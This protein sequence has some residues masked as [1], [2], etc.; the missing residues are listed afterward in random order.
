MASL[1]LQS[2]GCST[3]FGLPSHG[4]LDARSE[5]KGESFRVALLHLRQQYE[6]SKCLW[7]S[8]F[9]A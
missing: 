4:N 9:T 1:L 2:K 3:V 6:G 7:R 5:L 8:S